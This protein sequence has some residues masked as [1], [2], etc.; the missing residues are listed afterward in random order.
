MASKLI[1]WL[2][3]SDRY[4]HLI[5]GT[6]VGSFSCGLYCAAYATVLTASALE[7]K[8]KAHGGYWDWLDWLCTVAGGAIGYGIRSLIL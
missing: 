2:K 4:K 8:D 3:E 6:L 1:Q 7:Y 5:G